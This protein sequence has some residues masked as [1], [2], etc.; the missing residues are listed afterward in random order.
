MQLLHTLFT[1]RTQ[2]DFLVTILILLIVLLVV[3]NSRGEDF[4]TQKVRD[5]RV[6]VRKSIQERGREVIFFVSLALVAR[7]L[8]IMIL[9][10]SLAQHLRIGLFLVIL[11]N[12]E[13]LGKG[14]VLEY[15]ILVECL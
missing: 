2:L 3:L 15:V 10:L 9:D 7:S 12:D 11:I 5:A 8:A 6:I 4:V 13:L 14:L 1:V